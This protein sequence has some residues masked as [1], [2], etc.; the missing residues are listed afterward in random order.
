[1]QHTYF[2]TREAAV[3]LGL[4]L[5]T[6]NQYRA[7]GDGPRAIKLGTG[8]TARL[9][10]RRIALDRWMKSRAEKAAARTR[11]R[12]RAVERKAREAEKAAKDEAR[13]RKQIAEII[14]GALDF[15]MHDFA[16]VMERCG[17]DTIKG[18]PAEERDGFL[19]ALV[20]VCMTGG[21][22]DE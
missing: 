19:A 17:Y 21:S 13:F 3:Y 14:S 18:I 7:T 22:E 1:M 9:V 12:A 20:D 15:S 4:S 10:Y 6:I 2:S 11:A 8:K 16:E 5:Y